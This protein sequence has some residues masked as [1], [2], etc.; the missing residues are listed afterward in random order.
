MINVSNEDIIELGY[1]IY[2]PEIETYFLRF[3]QSASKSS[4]F[5]YKEKWGGRKSLAYTQPYI[6]WYIELPDSSQNDTY[7]NQ[8]EG[9]LTRTLSEGLLGFLV[10]NS[11]QVLA[12]FRMQSQRSYSNILST[13]LGAIFSLASIVVFV[14]LCSVGM[15]L[16]M[17]QLYKL[18]FD[19]K[20][21]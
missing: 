2:D 14:L 6:D 7:T 11:N 21:S 3:N 20:V 19:F 5:W 8:M 9:Y 4:V 17:S 12:Y 13:Q 15:Q 1:Y 18:I 16:K 10:W